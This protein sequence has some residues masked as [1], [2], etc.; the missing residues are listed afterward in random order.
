MPIAMRQIFQR[1][2]I[3]RVAMPMTLLIDS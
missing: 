3:T 2:M 1:R